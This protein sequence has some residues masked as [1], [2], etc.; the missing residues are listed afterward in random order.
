MFCHAHGLLPVSLP[1]QSCGRE[2]L[3]YVSYAGDAL[4]APKFGDSAGVFSWMREGD[5]IGLIM[6]GNSALTGALLEALT[7]PMPDP[8][9][10]KPAGH[11]VPPIF[12]INE[13]LFGG[14]DGG[15]KVELEALGQLD[16]H[17]H[18][19]LYARIGKRLLTKDT[20][21]FDNAL[22]NADVLKFFVYDQIFKDF[23][24]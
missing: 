10:R 22:K 11:T 9:G 14:G 19:Q 16:L 17:Q 15:E 6:N 2:Y 8:A 24:A 5:L 1:L 18:M 21:P 13:V 20:H 7:A 4:A 3:T 23:Q 12:R